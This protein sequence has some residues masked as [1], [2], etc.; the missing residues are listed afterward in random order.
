[1]IYTITFNPSLDYVVRVEDFVLGHSH[2]SLY[3]DIFAAGK[4]INVSTVL[5]TLGIDS[6]A[7][8]FCAGFTG[9]EIIHQLD[10]LGIS[11]DF[12]FLSQ[13]ISRINIKLKSNTDLESEINGQGPVITQE[14][15]ESFFTKLD[16]L[17]EGDILILSGSVPKS[18]P[19]A[20]SI[21]HRI[22]RHA[23]DKNLRL[24]LDADGDLLRNS[25]CEEPFLIKPNLQEL[26]KLFHKELTELDS[27]LDCA[28]ALREEGAK[29]VLISLGEKGALL[30]DEF[31]QVYRQTAP[32]G[33]VLNSVGSGDSMVAGF[34]AYLLKKVPKEE[35]YR[36]E[37]YRQAL[38]LGVATGS[39]AA[40][41]VGL[42]KMETIN[43][44]YHQLDEPSAFEKAYPQV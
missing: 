19:D 4:G 31:H 34:L 8:G 14:E 23:K 13:G 15:L 9:K 44:V 3:E 41:T 33:R 5:K 21:Y 7:L 36:T 42:P 30:V 37:H 2:Q 35:D 17:C 1:M 43:D 10:E 16:T 22:S 12:V 27:I 18:L 32:I 20:A 39:A 28:L 40:F 29:N 38:K 6:T 26:E 24:I 25:L 11:S